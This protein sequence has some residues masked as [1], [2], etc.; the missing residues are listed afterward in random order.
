MRK[1][2]ILMVMTNDDSTYN[3]DEDENH[4]DDDDDSGFD[5]NNEANEPTKDNIHPPGPVINDAVNDDTEAHNDLPVPD[6]R[7]S[8]GGVVSGDTDAT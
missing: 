6:D 5:D 3:P 8:Q 1:Y 4:D 7:E 2:Q